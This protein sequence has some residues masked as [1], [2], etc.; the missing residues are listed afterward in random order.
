MVMATLR[1]SAGLSFRA[2]I[3]SISI[4]EFMKWISF[5]TEKHLAWKGYI[6]QLTS[7]CEWMLRS[8]GSKMAIPVLNSELIV[9]WSPTLLLSL[10]MEWHGV[11]APPYLFPFLFPSLAIVVLALFWHSCPLSNIIPSLP[12]S[13][14]VFLYYLN[15]FLL[16]PFPYFLWMFLPS[17]FLPSNPLLSKGFQAALLAMQVFA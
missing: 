2:G 6:I 7:K 12:K 16:R 10:C 5:H 15:L 3:D 1:C 8:S 17:L 13:P 4:H 9:N 11:P 14:D